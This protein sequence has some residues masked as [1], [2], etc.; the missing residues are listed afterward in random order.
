MPYVPREHFLKISA[1]DGMLSRPFYHDSVWSV[2][3]QMRLGHVLC[4]NNNLNLPTDLDQRGNEQ[5]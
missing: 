3:N 2:H 4:P 5:Q 1:P